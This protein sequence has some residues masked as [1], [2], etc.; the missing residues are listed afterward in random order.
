[1]TFGPCS[2]RQ[3]R[4]ASE[5]ASSSSGG[6]MQQ[7]IK[8]ERDDGGNDGRSA[9]AKPHA[10]YDRG[11]YKSII[12]KI[13]RGCRAERRNCGDL[14]TSGSRQPAVR[15]RLGRDMQGKGGSAASQMLHHRGGHT[16]RRQIL[17]QQVPPQSSL[18][19]TPCLTLLGLSA[20]RVSLLNQTRQSNP[21]AP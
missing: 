12:W 19:Y 3:R 14:R 2:R 20:G 5:R 8:M 9:S 15:K 4:G 7:E 1:M 17:W 10:G 16:A 11:R 18:L 21:C 13:R 6:G